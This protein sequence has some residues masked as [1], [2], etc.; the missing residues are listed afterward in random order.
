MGTPL[1]ASAAT[2]GCVVN[3]CQVRHPSAQFPSQV[4]SLANT[5]DGIV[6]TLRCWC[7]TEQTQVTGK[8]ARAD[9]D[10][11]IAA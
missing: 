6:V 11:A 7:D 2:R 8:V 9:R 10:D 5:G 1:R 4:T 3:N